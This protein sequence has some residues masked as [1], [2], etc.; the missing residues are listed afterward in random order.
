[1]PRVALSLNL[2]LD[3]DLTLRTVLRWT[4]YGEEEGASERLRLDSMRRSCDAGW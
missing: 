3:L 4:V 2:D 1:M